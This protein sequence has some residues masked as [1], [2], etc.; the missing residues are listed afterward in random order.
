MRGWMLVVVLGGC[1]ET[2]LNWAGD[3]PSEPIAD[4]QVDPGL[5]NYGVV[6]N[7]VTVDEVVTLTS[8]GGLP[9]TV[10]ALSVDESTAFTVAALSEDLVLEPGESVDVIVSYTAESYADMG[11]LVVDSDAVE[12]EQVVTL[13][14]AGQYPALS[15][16]PTALTM[17]SELGEHV[18]AEV[19]VT[20]IGTV[21]LELWSMVVQG[22]W[23]SA[24]GEI[25]VTL[26]P[27]DSTTLT[28]TYTPELDGEIV[29]GK[30][31]IDTNTAAGSAVVPLEG[32]EE[33]DCMGLGEAWD[34]GELTG[35]TGFTSALKVRNLSSE[36]SI[37]ID[38]WYLWLSEGSQDLGAG[39]MAGDA[40]D[41]YPLGSLMIPPGGTEIFYAL[42]ETGSAWYCVEQTQITER[43]KQYTYLGARVPE[44][45]R[46]FMQ[47]GD[48][49]GSWA[50]QTQNPVMVA[51]RRT[52]LVE[53]PEEGGAETVTLR[54]LNLGGLAGVA[55]VRESIPAGM[56]A[57]GFSVEPLAV[58]D[59]EDGA[60]VY[61]FEVE[62]DGRIETD[63][64]T[65]TIYDEL[66]I[67]YTL[68][69]PPC[70]SRTYAPPMETRWEDSD[71]V[72]RTDT[73]NPLAIVC[74]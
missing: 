24:T 11:L 61:V 18:S 49:E 63:T 53:L 73:A 2:G 27:G 45:M 39:D 36:A 52:N 48:Q 22:R 70:E 56:S 66:E 50:W 8:V 23:F 21:D 29:V 6:A 33:P 40:G 5:I 47:N 65:H 1:S 32:R 34:R 25:P 38:D 44:P 71:G 69:V 67:S 60:T 10:H 58:E 12:P 15:L 4:L 37:C 19:E 14:G 9:V 26:P 55:E 51:A 57:G 54:I 7:E 28:V 72:E 35:Q 43:K 31:W 62:L 3:K 13:M 74:G 68:T 42:A 17:S 30:L 64:H 20:S 41:L 46:S 59:G 16:N